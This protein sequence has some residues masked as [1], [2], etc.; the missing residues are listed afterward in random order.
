MSEDSSGMNEL[1]WLMDMIQSVDVGLIVLDQNYQIEVW[2]TFM[3]NH[4]N[5]SSKEVH[6]KII[7]DLFPDADMK[8]I[9]SKIDTVFKLKNKAFSTWEQRSYLFKFNNYRPITGTERY[10]YQNI[11]IIPLA[12]AN[13]VVNHICL[14]V[15]DVTDVASQKKELI[16]I[17]QQLKQVVRTDSMTSL[18]NRRFWN[19]CLA[20]EYRRF[21]R[22]DIPRTLIICDIDSLEEINQRYSYK[23]GNLVIKEIATLLQ[24][25]QRDT[26]YS[27]RFSG[28][29]FAI[30]LTNV[31]DNSARVFAERLRLIVQKN[32][33]S[34]KDS[35]IKTTISLGVAELNKGCV[36]Q[37]GWLNNALHALQQAIN[38]GKNQTFLFSKL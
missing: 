13:G 24:S 33:I 25:T 7:F 37:T 1:H 35:E 11:S 17:K 32:V 2:N 36:D 20:I 38:A 27:C 29:Q 21:K 28:K 12:S 9:E 3:E 14:I 18:Y 19:E 8:W 23:V 10:M 31:T 6:S 34:A 5:L 22:N 26:D 16:N 15:Y 4:S 30:I